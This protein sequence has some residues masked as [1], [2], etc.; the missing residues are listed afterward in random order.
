VNNQ[1]PT[2]NS[3][4]V[5]PVFQQYALRVQLLLEEHNSGGLTREELGRLLEGT[6]PTDPQLRAL[7]DQRVTHHASEQFDKVKK[8]CRVMF[9]AGI[10]GWGFIWNRRAGEFRYHVMAKVV[11]GLRTPILSYYPA[12]QI[13]QTQSKEYA[14]RTRSA[15]RVALTHVNALENHAH[16]LPHGP[17][18]SALLREVQERLNA[19]EIRSLRLAA[20]NMDSGM[21]FE[22]FEQLANP[23]DRR[24]WI[25]AKQTKLYVEAQR[26]ANKELNELARMYEAFKLIIS[27]D[28]RELGEGA[29]VIDSA[30]P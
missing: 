20:L 29:G 21:K 14:T 23:R 16:S 1:N 24:L 13:A 28:P 8:V 6:P 2:S 11:N 10:E 15:T 17:D 26:R 5:D 18:R 30:K 27:R 7:Y 4:I 3:F 19:V 9:E 12:G 25:F 22:D